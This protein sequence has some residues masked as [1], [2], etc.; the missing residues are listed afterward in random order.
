MYSGLRC[1]KECCALRGGRVYLQFINRW[2]IRCLRDLSSPRSFAIQTS[3]F[4]LLQASFRLSKLWCPF[5]TRVQA[6]PVVVSERLEACKAINAVGCGRRG[7]ENGQRNLLNSKGN[8]IRIATIDSH[9]ILYAM[10][11]TIQSLPHIYP[12]P[13]ARGVKHL[14]LVVGRSRKI[15]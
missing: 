4:V 15:S 11:P 7:D 3:H 9:Y 2:A 8:C 14:L 1:W 13:L 6:K 12:S 5:P 10:P